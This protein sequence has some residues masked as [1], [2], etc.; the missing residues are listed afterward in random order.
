MS[1]RDKENLLILRD[2]AEAVLR[3]RDLYEVHDAAGNASLG[4]PERQALQS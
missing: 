4:H 3:N 1:E 2:P